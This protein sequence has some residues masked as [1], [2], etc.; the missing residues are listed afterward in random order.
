MSSNR[1]LSST[2]SRGI[3]TQLGIRTLINAAGTYTTLSGS[4]ML[5]EVVA[6]MEDAS[7]QHVEI[8]ELQ[9]IV[10]KR[11]AELVKVEA[12]LV[13]SGCAA[14]LTLGT[15]ACVQ[16][17]PEGIS[18]EN[19]FK[20]QVVLQ[21]SHRFS[22]D[23]AIRNVGVELIEVETV[24]ELNNAINERTGMLFFLNFLNNESK[25]GRKEFAQ[26]ANREKIP[27][28]IDAAA[29]LP[30]ARN[31]RILTEMGY[32]L[33]TFSGGKGLRGPQASGLLIG[34]EELVKAAYLHGPPHEDSVGRIGKV[35]KE[36]IIGLLK[37]IE[38][39]LERD[40]E[41]NWKEWEHQVD[42]IRRTI[43]G[44]HAVKAK[45][46]VP[47]IANEVPHLAISWDPKL[48]GLTRADVVN[49]L[50][51]GEPR[52]E[53][54]PDESHEPKIEIAVWML[55]PGEAEIVAQRCLEILRL[56]HEE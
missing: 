31:L 26:I 55:Q 18:N 17:S 15:A 33:A 10:G 27:A 22:F 35:S 6:A 16:T 19:T 14:A 11:I 34:R 2:E 25:I 41:A 7:K 21:K 51:T 5:P 39:Y 43:E 12:A 29:D 48:L 37:A 8:E 3:Y 45:P 54:R 30:P 24:D 28:L 42:L 53:V 52:I 1:P 36:G 40:H 23:R 9:Q 47:K 50:R 32:D 13:T 44:L 56:K 38:L 49:A 20:N 46:F 4:I